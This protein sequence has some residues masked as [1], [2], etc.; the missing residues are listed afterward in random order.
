M[1]S[2]CDETLSIANEF[3]HYNHYIVGTA[4]RRYIYQFCNLHVLK[5]GSTGIK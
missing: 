4:Y 5:Y 3:N 1:E 2:G